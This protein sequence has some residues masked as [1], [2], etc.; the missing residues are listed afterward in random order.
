MGK[1]PFE[2]EGRK[3]LVK[4]D[5]TTISDY[6]K[7]PS[8]R[9]V[10][11]LIDWGVINLNKPQGPTS[12]QV[13]GYV[14]EI[15]KL[16]HV[17]HGGTLDP[18]VTG[19]L[20]IALEKARRIVQ[21]LLSAGKEYVCLMHIH[22]EVD[23]KKIRNVFEEFL[24]KIE[25]IPPVRSAVKRR[26]RERQ[27]YYLEIL[28]IE[29]RDVL[30]KMGCQAGTYVRKLCDDIGKKLGTGAHM[31]ELIR[32]KAGPFKAEEWHTLHDIKDAYEFYKE[33]NEKELKS[34]ILPIEK[35]VEHLPKIW[36]FDNAVDTVCHGADLK[37]PGISKLHSG[38]N[39]GEM[40]AVMTLKDE[41]VCLGESSKDSESMIKEQKGLA[42]KTKKVFMD[43][44]T[45]PKFSLSKQD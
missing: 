20:P 32:T 3:I 39:E 11:E 31:A 21:A 14:K 1:L 42:V 13:A 28:E 18:N 2:K 30:F 43:R 4:K 10:E 41:L 24:G 36:I 25:Q 27:I 19:V 12:H 17:G 6:G 9:K 33:G 29:G 44:G 35:A 15:L 26:K 5:G 16:D 45:Y 38:I 22:K 40:V 7:H 23:E 34:I 37:L 8:E